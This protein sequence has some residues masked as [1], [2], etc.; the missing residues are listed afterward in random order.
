MTRIPGLRR[1]VRIERDRAGVARAVDD[2]M[3]FPFDMTMREL[4][5]NGMTPD[6]AR[7][8]T[9]RRFG[10]VQRTREKLA[11]IDRSRVGR[12]RRAEWWGAFAQDFR[13]AIRGLRLKPGFALAVVVTLGLGIGANATMF[14]IVDR[15]LFRPPAYL[16]APGRAALVYFGTTNR[17]KEN[18]SSSASY[19]TFVDLKQYTT[20]FDVIAPFFTDQ[21]AV[22][23]GAS[24]KEMKVAAAGADMWRLFDVAPVIGR[25]YTAQ[26]DATPAGTPVAV[27]SY[28]FWQTQFGGRRDALGQQLSIGA[29]KY[30]IIGVAPN[31]FVAFSSDPVV[32]FVPMSAESNAEIGPGFRMGRSRFPWYQN[33]GRI[34]LSVFARRKPG[35]SLAAANVDLN[36]AFQ[37]SYK[38]MLTVNP[39]RTAFD[40]ARPRAYAGSV[41]RDRGPNEDDSAKVAS[42]LTG[43]A[44]I[45][46]LIACANV[47]NLLLARA[48]RRRREIA[49]RVAL[50]VSRLRLLMQLLTESVVLA[51]LGG[52]AGLAVAQWGGGI[53]RRALFDDDV[54]VGS[55]FADPRTLAVVGVLVISIGLLTGL[56][57]VFQASSS[58]VSAALKAGAREGTVHRSRLRA[59]LLILQA[60]LSVVL[61][62]GAGLFLRS[63]VNVENV[64][65]GYDASRLLWVDLQSRGTQSDSAHDA[66]LRDQLLER[67]RQLPSVERSARGLTVPFWS[68]WIVS[69]YVTGIDSVGALGQFTVQAGSPGFLQTMGTRLVRGRSFT[70]ADAASA[71]KVMIVGESMAK[72]L[73]PN[74]DALGKCVRV[75][76]DTAPCTTVVGIAQDV[77]RSSIS[78]TE[79]HYYMPTAQFRPDQG[80]L[81]I[82]MRGS[83][84]DHAEEVRRALQSIM[85]G[86][87]Y[88]TI[89]PMSTIIAPQ[90]RSWK[91]GAV[92]FAAFGALALALAAIGLYSVIAY[93]V[94]QRMHEMGVRVA[95]GAQGADVVRLV[96]REGVV[97]VLP[98]VAL[99]T[100]VALAG[101][102]WVAPLLFQVSPKDPPVLIGVI[103]MLIVVAISA[104][105]IPATRAAHVDPQEALRAD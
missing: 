98:G 79:M 82:R 71:P 77:R 43:V 52:V 4:M 59:G 16:A 76:A 99:G 73:W 46:L 60:A 3:Q 26:E 17:A 97:T 96:V 53:M 83:A 6:D 89:T 78:E 14:G 105:W 61:L 55:A 84:A 9:E 90:I 63:L 101:G 24:T 104:S 103:A 57:P 85:P 91:L 45:V 49:V 70:E 18:V 54:T 51:A 74:E 10:D 69:L 75:L 48:L 13:Y 93:N 41:L 33:Y 87:S 100:I 66:L 65:M 88:V 80:G 72:R 36:R 29:A 58:D 95:L 62:V 50:G 20:S 68:T 2:E 15:L 27:L 81:F 21:L 23:E 5:A 19:P 92:M 47:A 7:R 86:A 64:P 44:A 37:L 22:G 40:L 28:T 30:T 12:E 31:G 35:V 32:A 94:A 42:W 8:E 38:H 102:R 11:T 1:L 25:F 56:A 34:W 67:A 39:K